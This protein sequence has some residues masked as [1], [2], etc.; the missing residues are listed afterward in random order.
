MGGIGNI[1]TA[2][3]KGMSSQFNNKVA[4]ES[5]NI[6]NSL[7]ISNSQILFQ[8]MGNGKI[9]PVPMQFNQFN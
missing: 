3:T 4:R 8:D 6:T 2:P 7:I 5:L 1:I 9:M